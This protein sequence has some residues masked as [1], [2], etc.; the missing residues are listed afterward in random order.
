MKI[1]GDF[2]LKDPEQ[3]HKDIE[4]LCKNVKS[5]KDETSMHMEKPRV[6]Y[7]HS[8]G[9]NIL[10][11]VID[12][13]P[14]KDETSMNKPKDPL[15]DGMD[16]THPMEDPHQLRTYLFLLQAVVHKDANNGRSPS[17]NEYLHQDYP[18]YIP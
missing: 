15:S 16:E 8:D 12:D 2:S 10:E 11:D 4:Q 17:H 13:I 9:L 6:N 5:I 3:L 7:L 18:H 1:H 14:N